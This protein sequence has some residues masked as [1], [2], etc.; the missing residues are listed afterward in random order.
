MK[1][2]WLKEC[3]LGLLWAFMIATTYFVYR[4]EG[5]AGAEF[6]YVGF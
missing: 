2:K 4:V 3:L 5:G 6:R 1:K